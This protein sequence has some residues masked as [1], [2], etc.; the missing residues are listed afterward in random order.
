MP[1]ISELKVTELKDLLRKQGL[2]VSGTKDELIKRLRG[3][4]RSARKVKRSR[5]PRRSSRKSGRKSGRKS[6]RKSGRKSGR[7]RKTP[8]RSARK[9][10]KRSPSRRR[11][12]RR[13]S[14]K[15]SRKSGRKSVR[16]SGRKS[17]KK[18][19][20]KDDFESMSVKD[21]KKLARHKGLS[22]SGRKEDIIE[23]LRT[24]VSFKGYQVLRQ[25]GT[26]G[27][28]GVTYLVKKGSKE[29]ALKSFKDK[30]PSHL[31]EEEANFQKEAAKHNIAPKVF[32]VNLNE[33]YITMEVMDG[34]LKDFVREHKKI[35]MEDQKKILELYKKLDKIGIYHFDSN[36]LNV[37]YKN[38]KNGREWK[39]IDYGIS[40]KFQK[41]EY[42]K[43]MNLRKLNQM[44]V[45]GYLNLSDL[46]SEK[47]K[48]LLEHTKKP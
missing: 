37:M 1:T 18:H 40:K 14:R 46:L 5:S 42:G 34:T 38:T 35:P 22:L 27:L 30:K 15:S 4:K 21:L 12:P 26:A 36:P 8:K 20:L 39:I 6:V 23:R 17:P 45:G 41:F 13:S 7:K 43:W 24:P 25:L 28:D 2:K 47:P 29:Y 9:I 16:R 3:V 10:A 19:T 33:K 32:D 31:I 11:S 48:Y 44:L